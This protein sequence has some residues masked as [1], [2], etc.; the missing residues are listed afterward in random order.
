MI[1]AALL[2]ALTTHA[3]WAAPKVETIARFTAEAGEI[4][5]AAWLG[6][7]RIGLLYPE[8]GHIAEYTTEGRLFQHTVRE[9]GI[10][11]PFRPSACIAGPGD[12]LLVFDEAEQKLFEVEPDGNFSKGLTLALDGEAGK[13][14][15]LSRVADI[16]WQPVLKNGEQLPTTKGFITWAMPA[17][18]GQFCSFGRDGKQSGVLSFEQMLPYA[19]AMY[20][21]PQWGA[22]GALFVL[23]YAQGAVLYKRPSESKF[24]RIRVGEPPQPLDGG[25]SVDAVP[26]LQD[27][28]VGADGRILAATA[29]LKKPLLLLSPGA[30]G[31]SSS[32]VDLKIPA[33]P[34]R[35]GVRFSRG[36]YIVWLRES[37]EV[38]VLK[39]QP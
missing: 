34:A 7:G 12:E 39:V 13:S 11:L 26:A 31:Y 6:N 36:K 25:A 9:A 21:R 30:K 4:A 27:F 28:A 22:D 20:A 38:I 8:L 33:E 23:D 1:L 10:G 32:K 18:G 3:V 15:A 29:D 5:D 24:R 35:I 2:S 37:C 16:A 19:N 17:E 14:I